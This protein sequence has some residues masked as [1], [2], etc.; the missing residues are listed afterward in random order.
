MAAGPDAPRSE[1]FDA[2]PDP[3]MVVDPA[4]T[5]VDVNQAALDLLG[6]PREDIIGMRVDGL[7]A[8]GA[9]VSRRRLEQLIRGGFW[10]G[11]LQLRHA[12]GSTIRV[13][14]TASVVQM[15]DGPRYVAVLR[16]SEELEVLEELALAA[17]ARLMTVMDSV[18]D[19]II[20][21][22]DQQRIQVFNSAAEEI[23]RCPAADAVGRP[24]ERFIPE[25]FRVAHH[26]DVER[27]AATGVTARTMGH[28]GTVLGLRADGEEFFMEATISKVNVGGRPT[29][30]VIARDVSPRSQLEER[31]RLEA[32]IRSL[33][34]ATDRFGD[35]F[36]ALD[37]VTDAVLRHLVLDELLDD[38]LERLNRVLQA[39]SATVLLLDA[40]RGVLVRRASVG[41]ESEYE[42]DVAVPVGQGIDGTVAET[43][44][45]LLVPDTSTRTVINPAIRR[46]LRSLVAVPLIHEDELIGVLHVGSGA[47]N[48]FTETDVRF[49]SVVAARLA[50]S[51][52]NAQLHEALEAAYAAE[53]R[54]RLQAEEAV[55]W[56]NAL[57]QVTAALASARTLPE[58]TDLLL[59][60]ATDAIRATA[61]TVMLRDGDALRL[62]ASRGYP[63]GSLEPWAVL[64]LSMPVPVT[65]AVRTRQALWLPNQASVLEGFPLSAETLEDF[66]L[67]A[68]IAL[69]LVVGDHAIG[70]LSLQFG[71]PRTFEPDEIEL[72]QAI[73]R[74]FAQ[75]H[76]RLRLLDVERQV[77]AR[78]R[79]LIEANIVGVM[80]ERAD[81]TVVEANDALLSLLGFTREDLAA[82]AIDWRRLTPP[83]HLSRTM[84]AMQEAETRG[85][86]AP[87]E[88]E[89]FRKDGRRV[90]VLVGLAMVAT[91]PFE[92]IAYVFDLSEREAA[93][94]ERERLLEQERRARDAA[95]VA[96]ERLAFLS[97]SSRLLA[98]S[99]DYA[100]T[101]RSVA[102]AAVP[103][104]ADWCAIDLITGEGT[105]ERLVVEHIEPEKVRFAWKLGER[106]PIDLD[107]PSPTGVAHVLRTNTPELMEDIPRDAIEAALEATPDIREAIL[108]LELRSA[109]IVPLSFGGEV[110]GA[111]TFVMAESGRNY[112]GVD[113]SLAEELARRAAIAIDN[114][115]LYER[116]RAARREAELATG[117]LRL[118]TDL[119]EALLSAF[120]LEGAAQALARFLA[121]RVGDYAVI[122][123]VG[124]DGQ[125][126]HVLASAR[127]PAQDVSL[128]A[129]MGIDRP[130]LDDPE[131]LVADTTKHGQSTLIATMVDE[132]L[133]RLATRAQLSAWQTLGCASSVVVPIPLRDRVLGTI[134]ICRSPGSPE[135]TEDDLAF[136]RDVAERAAQAL[137]NARLY[138]ERAYVADTLQRSLLPPSLAEVPGVSIGVAYR[139]AGDGTQVGGDFYDVFETD[140]EEWAVSIGDVCGKGS[141]AAAI[142]ALSRYTIRTAALHQSRP[143]AIL[144]TLN[145]ALLRQ[146]S[147]TRFCTACQ[148]R[149]RR[150]GDR[151]RLT[152]ACGGHPLPI[153]LRADGTLG[154]AGVPGTLLGFFPDPTLT[155]R[156]EDLAPGDTVVLYTDGLTDVRDGEGELGEERVMDL[157]RDCQGASA[158]EI[159]TR[160]MTAAI[161]FREEDP[162]DDI[163]ILA[164]QVTA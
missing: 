143:S 114:A 102:R 147:E 74:L 79:R 162:Q 18:V 145:E 84:I 148:V 104:L 64:P 69:P 144:S 151:L 134:V 137:D 110:L 51:I 88:K 5:C 140:D 3:V 156:V 82:G 10:R 117:R 81:G 15:D 61:G 40:Q 68:L 4:G 70:S 98:S 22:D 1:V 11:P 45:P 105:A 31:N 135:L 14:L 63:D 128:Q 106:F 19:A 103:R 29:L 127:D 87:Y 72:L 35:L 20:T 89:Y 7:G 27:F 52:A 121:E 136:L 13:F 139:P 154:A 48:R 164:V 85:G 42:G 161:D 146:T 37:T 16:Q 47:A 65:E 60:H 43:Q 131:S 46:F 91:D 54:Q 49:V 122:Y 57:Q 75:T 2:L 55:R 96:N 17:E 93:A 159:V 6:Y 67:E 59:E 133:A 83:E 112:R 149:M 97:E 94:R 44:R 90:P 33:R 62:M 9:E 26:R 50:V 30:T 130:D 120:D 38:L 126:G 155:D 25:R 8:D 115:R 23:F 123:L 80:V 119:D 118:L 78:A 153:I 36:Q 111:I 58:A 132:D 152:V 163:A 28:P 142:M 24:I 34:G 77:S 73:A 158:D 101:L 21:V 86:S 99:L 141:G 160:L 56:T 76:E 109:M 95:E 116:E 100:A 150:R 41:L 125:I 157:L 113:L 39:D 53:H 32:D 138:G 71:A 66:G 108:A 129:I 107:D 12:D 92:A 124:R